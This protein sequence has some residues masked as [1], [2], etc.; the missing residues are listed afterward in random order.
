[1]L[2]TILMGFFFQNICQSYFLDK[3]GTITWTYS[4]WL[5][6]RRVV[7]C[8][9]KL[10]TVLIFIFSKLFWFMFFG[11]IWSQPEVLQINWNLIQSYIATCLLK[12]WC[13][14]SRNFVIHI[15]LGKFWQNLM[16]SILIAIWHKGTLLH[17]DCGFDV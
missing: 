12:F 7:H 2:I 6:F 16:F 5:K 4:N 8:Y 13:L 3:F 17:G 14:V 11:Q 1:M 9:Y 15:I 10:I